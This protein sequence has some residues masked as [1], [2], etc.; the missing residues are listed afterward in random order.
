M[1]KYHVTVR[2]AGVE[3]VEAENPYMAA[4]GAAAR[5]GDDVEVADVRPAVGRTASP[6]VAATQRTVTKKR[7]PLS[8]EARAKLA[9]NLEKARAARARKLKAV[10]KTTKKPATKARAAK[11]S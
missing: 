3:V 11:R 6:A 7:R 2:V 8:P 10:R 9:K 1:P 4:I 5:H